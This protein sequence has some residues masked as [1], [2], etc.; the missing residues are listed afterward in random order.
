MFQVFD[1]FVI[2]Y[3]AAEEDA[4]RDADGTAE[5]VVISKEIKMIFHSQR[6]H[7]WKPENAHGREYCLEEVQPGQEEGIKERAIKSRTLT[8][9]GEDF[10]KPW[11][12][13][14]LDNR[15]REFGDYGRVPGHIES[16]QYVYGDGSDLMSGI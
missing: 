3:R 11:V 1:Q 15:R 10:C 13:I 12:E 16:S 2:I 14:A 5:S 4:A 8:A 7:W 6:D 9:I